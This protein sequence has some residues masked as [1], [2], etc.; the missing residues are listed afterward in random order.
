MRRSEFGVVP[1]P[2]PRPKMPSRRLLLER[3]GVA[4]ALTL[5]LVGVATAGYVFS[6]PLPKGSPNVT[7]YVEPGASTAKVADL[8][9]QNGVVRNPLAFRALARIMRADG[10]LQSGEYQF[11]PGIFAWDAISSLVHGRVLYYSVTVREGLTV[12]QIA[13]LVEGRGF[14]AKADIL[15]LCK[16]SS[17]LPA[18]VSAADRAGVRYPLEGYLFPDTY[19]I[20]RGM[21]PKEIV[22]MMVSRFTAVF[23]A[24]LANKA[25][26]RG[27]SAHDA[28]TLA[29]IVEREAYAPEERAVIAAVYLNRLRIG[30]KLDADPTVVYAIGKQAGYAPLYKDLEA[31]SPYNTYRNAGLPPGPIGNFGKASLEAVLAPASVDYLYF[32]AKKDGT[33]AFAR[34]LS[35]HNQNVRK[36]QGN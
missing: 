1:S 13:T 21:T 34:T 29:S 32:V 10:R 14:G 15:T 8:L 7:V 20:R 27:I 33:H 23:T 17:L 18:L 22:Q 31:D 24:E 30:M 36:Y 26:S 16:D 25:K 12:E 28:A 5:L 19:Y 11:E 3:F 9:H 6:C 35:D 2:G 4:I